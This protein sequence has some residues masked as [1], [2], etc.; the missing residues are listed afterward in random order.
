MARHQTQRRLRQRLVRRHDCFGDVRRFPV[1]RREGNARAVRC[2]GV[3]MAA[4][5]IRGSGESWA[6]IKLY[7]DDREEIVQSGLGRIEAEILCVMK[8]KD[9]RKPV[10]AHVGG[11]V[12]DGPKRKRARQLT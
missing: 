3:L 5:F 1:A 12:V 4:Y 10:V 8:L 7:P 6:V 2:T 11:L 9:L